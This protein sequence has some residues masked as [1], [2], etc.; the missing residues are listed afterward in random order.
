MNGHELILSVEFF[1]TETGREPVRDWLKSLPRENRKI[2]GEDIKTVQFGWP[3][4]MPLV[5]KVGMRLWE[6]RVR[7]PHGIARV[8]FTTGE[9]RMILLHG[10]IKKSQKAPREDLELAKTRLRMLL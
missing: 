9:R 5:R 1:R 2:I 8:L 3:L 6:V 4:G 10:F 7:L